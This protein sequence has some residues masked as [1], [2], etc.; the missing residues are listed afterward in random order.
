LLGIFDDGD[1]LLFDNDVGS[2]HTG[3]ED[4]GGWTLMTLTGGSGLKIEQRMDINKV[5]LS[6]IIRG[7]WGEIIIKI[8]TYLTSPLDVIYEAATPA[9]AAP[10]VLAVDLLLNHQGQ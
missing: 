8:P 6:I 2:E 9:A 4:A 1:F 10:F 5:E 3:A 7:D